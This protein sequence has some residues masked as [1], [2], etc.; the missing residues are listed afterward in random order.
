MRRLNLIIVMWMIGITCAAIVLHINLHV[1][2]CSSEHGILRYFPNFVYMALGTHLYKN[3][4]VI[5]G[6]SKTSWWKE[7]NSLQL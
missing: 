3:S 5:T 7:P 4:F 1:H 2:D 6:L